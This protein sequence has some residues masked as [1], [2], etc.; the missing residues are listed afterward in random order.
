MKQRTNSDLGKKMARKRSSTVETVF[1]HLKY[2]RK[3]RRFIY[4]GMNMIDNIWKF[5]LAVYNLEQIIRL[6]KLGRLRI[7]I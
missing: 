4:R 1:A 7:A 3:L 2:I 5:E 6:H